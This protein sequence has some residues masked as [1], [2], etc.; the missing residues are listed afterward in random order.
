[1]LYIAA[2]GHALRRKDIK[3]VYTYQQDEVESNV[4]VT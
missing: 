3:E 2:W 4:A 1:M